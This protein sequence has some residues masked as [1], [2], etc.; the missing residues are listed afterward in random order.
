MRLLL[1]LVIFA[2][3]LFSV[4]FKILNLEPNSTIKINNKSY[5]VDS[6]KFEINLKEGDYTI[7]ISHNDFI[8]LRFDYEV[9]NDKD[10]III[11]NH[12]ENGKIEYPFI[13]RKNFFKTV[14]ID[15]KVRRGFLKVKRKDYCNEFKC[16]ATKKSSLITIFYKKVSPYKNNLYILKQ[17]NKYSYFTIRA[18]SKYT[19]STSTTT[20]FNK[21]EKVILSPISS[22]SMFTL[23]S[24]AV[25]YNDDKNYTGVV[26][27]LGYRKNL[28]INIFASIRTRYLWFFNT[29]TNE[30]L[31][32]YQVGGGIGYLA[33]NGLMLEGGVLKNHIK[34]KHIENNKVE[35]YGE[36][37]YRG[38]KIHYSPSTT[39]INYINIYPFRFLW[40]FYIGIGQINKK[41]YNDRGIDI[42]DNNAA[43]WHA[44][45]KVRSPGVIYN[46]LQVNFLGYENEAGTNTLKGHSYGVG[47]GVHISR[48]A[49]EIGVL[50]DKLKFT[51]EDYANDYEIN[52]NI[53]EMNPYGEIEYF[54]TSKG[55][56][57]Y[58]GV[59]SLLY[60]KN[61]GMLS[62]GWCF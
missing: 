9:S 41:V 37:S 51:Y 21:D 43:G 11:L 22:W 46:S 35:P 10:N 57:K 59:F 44:R 30:T 52:D 16:E 24:G 49:L 38:L 19:Y 39:E 33:S 18:D 6:N 45:L 47:L 27:G 31:K 2:N 5:R 42:G 58:E 13:K 7:T 1:V 48:I 23:E 36:L 29:E 25:S 15:Y 4:T 26:I 53:D 50:K 3:F 56:I 54:F 17:D 40:S 34:N 20:D 60:T 32:G 28:P 61:Y 14:E 55:N 62:L 12:E 8:P